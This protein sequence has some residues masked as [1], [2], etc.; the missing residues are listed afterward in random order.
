MSSHNAWIVTVDMGYGHQRAAY[1][2]RDFSPQGKVVVANN[3]QGIPDKDRRVWK[4]IR[5]LYET[6]SRLYTVPLIGPRLFG[7]MDDFQALPPFYPRRDLSRPTL[8]LRQTYH[9]IR[10]GWGKDLV[11]FLNTKH[12][13]LI[14]TFFTAAYMAE[15]HG[16]K[17]DIYVTVCDSD[18]SRAWAPLE[19]K[20]SRIKY[21]APT[22]RVVERLKLYGVR[23]DHI[24]LTGF[25]LPQENIGEN[26]NIIKSDIMN[27]IINLDPEKRYQKKYAETLK[28][29]FKGVKMDG[30]QATHPLTL[31]FAVGGAGAQRS[32]ADAILKSLKKKLLDGDINLNLVAGCRNE[33]F[34]YF[35]KKI[36]ELGLEKIMDKNIKIIFA[37]EKEDYFTTFNETVRTTDI[38]WTK[39]SELSFYCALGL[40]II[41][42]PPIGSQEHFNREWLKKI[43][44]GIDQE[45]SRYTHEWLFDSINS[46]WLA[47]AAISGFL[48]GRQFGVENIVDVVFHGEKTP[49]MDDELL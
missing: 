7:I 14:A 37:L 21:L 44:G 29:F 26:L 40:P 13:P 24:F 8:Q 11:E 23:D 12:L 4:N 20:K 10:R 36:T 18:I 16:F 27:R 3:Y 32:I 43:G 9:S 47:E 22:R 17:H 31:T 49:E 1:P 25:P 38:L 6:V 35:K 28:Q 15:E 42:A 39:P 5:S 2:L 48:D 33:V 46:G 41:I 45:D 30:L 19:P 34:L